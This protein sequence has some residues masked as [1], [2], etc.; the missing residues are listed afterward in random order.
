MVLS[1]LLHTSQEGSHYMDTKMLGGALA[2]LGVIGAVVGYALWHSLTFSSKKL[3][4]A[5][6]LGVLFLIVG[7]VL[8]VMP[9]KKVA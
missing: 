5:V 6:G 8:A 4:L 1:S 2:A 3:D 9:S 7:V